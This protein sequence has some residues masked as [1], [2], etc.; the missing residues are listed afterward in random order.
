MYFTGMSDALS[1]AHGSA[2]RT[3]GL[4][5]GGDSFIVSS[6]AWHCHIVDGK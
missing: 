4:Q 5:K 3:Q 2:L 6:R 1:L